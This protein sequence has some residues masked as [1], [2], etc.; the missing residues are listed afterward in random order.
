[1]RCPIAAASVA[2]HSVRR[3][4]PWS[5]RRSWR[6]TWIGFVTVALGY[7]V[8]G[9]GSVST[10]HQTIMDA[11]DEY[12]QFN[13]EYSYAGAELHWQEEST[14]SGADDSDDILEF[15]SAFDETFRER[16]DSGIPDV[17]RGDRP[18]KIVVTVSDVYNPG[19]LA[20]GLAFRDP[21]IEITAIVQAASDE[22]AL[23]AHETKVVD[24]LPP[25]FSGGIQ[26]RIGKI[27]DRLARQA[28]SDL[29]SW[30]RSLESP[31]PAEEQS[32]A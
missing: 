7:L 4:A 28:V 31:T 22:E 26:F 2:R 1:M 19:A 8:S 18:V 20:R 6:N 10:V 15:R 32:D 23:H 11:T 5:I 25:D 13:T 17:L 30:L 14:E 21:S 16:M 3:I 27:P 9:C 12:R 29:M 24:V